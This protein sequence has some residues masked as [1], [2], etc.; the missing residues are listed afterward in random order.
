MA[1]GAL[2]ILTVGGWEIIENFVIDASG[3]KA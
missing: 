2:L 3:W 1:C